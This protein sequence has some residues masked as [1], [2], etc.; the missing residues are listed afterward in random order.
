MSNVVILECDTSSA[1]SIAA[2][3]KQVKSHLGSTRIAYLLNNAGINSH[4]QEKALSISK[5]ALLAQIS[6]NVL[7]PAEIVK[8]LAP[9]L[10]KGSVVMNMSSGLGSVALARDGSST[11]CTTYSI[12]KAALNM[13]TAH[14]AVE[15][16]EAGVVVVAM[17]P[18]WVKTRMGGDG[19]VL[20]AHNSI[21]SMVTVLHGLTERDTGKFYRYDGEFVPW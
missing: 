21:A 9:C 8:S 18:G 14:Q 19:A 1:D 17:D 2:F 3:A 10:G 11:L 5:D 6:T 15:L 12:S 20:E 13:L 16:K 4:P 7:G